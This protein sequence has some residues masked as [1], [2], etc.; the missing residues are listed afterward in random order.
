MTDEK[1]KNKIHMNSTK[2]QKTE[3]HLYKKRWF[4]LC[5]FISFTFMNSLQWG[6]YVIISN[7]VAKFYQVPTKDVDWTSVVYMV[8][9]IPLIFPALWLLDKTGIRFC[10][11]FSCFGL[12]L[13]AWIKV[14]AS[15]NSS[16]F[17]FV[18]T[19]Q[20]TQAVFQVLAFGFAA[21]VAA[22][23]FGSHEVSFACA[24]AVFGDQLGT[25]FGFLVPNK[26]VTGS[27]P[28]EIGSNLLSL[29]LLI[30]VISTLI[31]L[32]A[33]LFFKECPKTPPSAA[34]IIQKG[35]KEGTKDNDILNGMGKAFRSKSSIK[36][37]LTYGINNACFN[38]YVMLFNDIFIKQFKGIDNVNDHIGVLGALIMISGIVGSVIIGYL[39]DRTHLYKATTLVSYFFSS[40]AALFNA[41]AFQSQNLDLVY[42]SN[43][44]IGFCQI[45]YYSIAIQFCIETMYPLSEGFSSSLLLLGSHILGILFSR[46]GRKVYDSWGYFHTCVGLAIL[47]LLGTLLT[48]TIPSKLK[49]YN[50][51][52]LILNETPINAAV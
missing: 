46:T 45:G 10:L 15:T 33:L 20:A 25:A 17:A 49:R 48:M 34:Q 39:L 4:M 30:A 32:T 23:W 14:Y 24:L 51:E 47:L 11:T 18:L 9:Y 8:A 6:E 35:T 28:E 29:N 41:F 7:L 19:G 3:F 43:I 50:A 5:I 40:L 21:R 2:N 44:L 12:A 52:R 13:G 22:L 38:T 1:S 37:I 42:L 27:T 26:F 36:M 31:F 16:L